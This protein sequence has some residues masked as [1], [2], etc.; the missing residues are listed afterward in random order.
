MIEPSFVLNKKYNNRVG[1]TGVFE[2]LE[3]LEHLS[4][5][6]PLQYYY[7]LAASLLN[8]LQLSE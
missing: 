7:K 1:Y 5:S 6:T 8:T 2:K 4:L 3:M